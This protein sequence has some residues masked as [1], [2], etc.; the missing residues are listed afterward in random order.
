MSS[1]GQM[2]LCFTEVV[3][4]IILAILSSFIGEKVFYIIFILSMISTLGINLNI[5]KEQL[6]K[7]N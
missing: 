7:E 6:K 1:V 4:F 3:I 2:S 5:K